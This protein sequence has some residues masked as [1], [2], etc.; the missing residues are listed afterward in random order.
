MLD[1]L[2][3]NAVRHTPH[4]GRVTV[5]VA[6]DHGAVRVEVCN[7]GAAIDDRVAGRLFERYYRNDTGNHPDGAGL[8]LAIVKRILELH[9]SRIRVRHD[10]ARGTCFHFALPRFERIKKPAAAVPSAG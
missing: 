7:T 4:G 1:N 10:P 6:D 9:G 2:L 3:D 5:R 8:G